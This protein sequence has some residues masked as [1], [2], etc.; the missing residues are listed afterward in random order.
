ME[1]ISLTTWVAAFI[2]ARLFSIPLAVV[3][4]DYLDPPSVRQPVAFVALFVATL[5]V[6]S[7]I[8]RLIYELVRVS[9]LTK[10]DRVL[11]MGFGFLR[12][13]ILVVVALSFASN[14]KSMEVSKDPW[15][16]QSLLIPKAMMVEKWSADKG[17]LV[18]NKIM[19]ISSQETSS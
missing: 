17:T 7:L 11:G 19:E 10:T 13:I 1:A 15:W 9:G 16:Q 2:I 6:G 18:W 3:L 12:G 8:K 14:M 4:T 5:I